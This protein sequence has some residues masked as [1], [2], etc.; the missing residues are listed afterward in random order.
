MRHRI[1]MLKH[2]LRRRIVDGAWWVLKTLDPATVKLLVRTAHVQSAITYSKAVEI[3]GRDYVEEW[4]DEL[5]VRMDF[6]RDTS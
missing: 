2:R 4:A 3:L 5:S 1:F 6:D